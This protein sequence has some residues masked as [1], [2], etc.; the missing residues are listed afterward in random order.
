MGP[1][2]GGFGISHGEVLH[3][4][5]KIVFLEGGKHRFISFPAFP[6]GFI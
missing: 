3:G 6:G 1:G 4:N 5:L 2:D